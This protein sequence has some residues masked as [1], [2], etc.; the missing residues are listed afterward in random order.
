MRAAITAHPGDLDLLTAT[1]TAWGNDRAFAGAALDDLITLLEHASRRVRETALKNLE[2]ATG[3][4]LGTTPSAWRQWKTTQ[5][6]TD[7]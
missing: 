4:H 7:R 2:R 1:A 5:D 6:T 3:Q